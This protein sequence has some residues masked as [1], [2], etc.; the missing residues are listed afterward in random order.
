MAFQKGQE[1]VN[2]IILYGVTIIVVGGSAFLFGHWVLRALR[3][4]GWPQ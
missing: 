1:V 2:T 3:V 4:L